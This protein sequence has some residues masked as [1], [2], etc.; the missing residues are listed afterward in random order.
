MLHCRLVRLD[1]SIPQDIDDDGALAKATLSPSSPSSVT[2]GSASFLWRE[3][4]EQQ[5]HAL[6]DAVEAFFRP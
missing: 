5:I 3:K 2:S 6:T 4:A 1:L